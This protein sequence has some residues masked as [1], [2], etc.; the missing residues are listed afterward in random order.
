[1]EVMV[2]IIIPIFNVELY[3]KKCIESI[4]AQTYANIEVLLVDDGS[5]DG[6]R[7]ICKQYQKLDSRVKVFTQKNQGV[8]SARN[9]GLENATGK[10]IMFVDADD[11]VA[12][13]IVQDLLTPL[14]ENNDVIMSAGRGKVVYKQE[15]DFSNEVE[16]LNEQ[17]SSIEMVKRQFLGVPYAQGAC[18]KI[19]RRNKI[20]ALRFEEGI[21]YNEDSYFTYEYCFKNKGIIHVLQKRLYAY[22]MREDSATHK[23]FKKEKLSILNLARKKCEDCQTIIELKEASLFGLINSI[24]FI[25]KDIIRSNYYRKEYTLIKSLRK[26]ALEISLSRLPI[27]NRKKRI[28]LVF[29]KMGLKAYY[30]FVRTADLF[31]KRNRT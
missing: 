12:P 29:F 15:Y 21:S 28:E 14:E 31:M 22:Y 25:V 3:V 2:S 13:S 27:T 16:A 1:M 17:I 26:E 5:T 10:Y 4:L 9:K 7:E 6:S 18:V 20:S 23:S 11:F 8:S 30:F 24:L 19:F